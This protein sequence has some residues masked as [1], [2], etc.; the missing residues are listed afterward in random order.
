[1]DHENDP[2]GNEYPE[3]TCICFVCLEQFPPQAVT[4]LSCGTHIGCGPC[5][6][7]MFA[8]ALK[9]EIS[10]PPSCC[11]SQPSIPLSAVEHVLETSFI[12]EYKTKQIEYATDPKS[13]IYCANPRCSTFLLQEPGQEGPA[14]TNIDCVKCGAITCT[15]CKE[16]ITV[17]E[18]H[19]CKDKIQNLG[20]DKD[21]RSKPCP[22]CRTSVELTDAC[23]H[24]R[25]SVC[26]YEFCFV[27]LQWQYPP[28]GIVHDCPPYGDPDY[29]ENGYDERGFHRDTGLDREGY[30]LAG[31]NADHVSR[32]GERR[33]V[34]PVPGSLVELQD[35]GNDGWGPERNLDDE[36]N[37]DWN[38]GDGGQW[39]Q[40]VAQQWD[41][42][43]E[44]PAEDRDEE[45]ARA[46]GLDD[47]DF[48]EDRIVH[49]IR[50]L[51]LDVTAN[52]ADYERDWEIESDGHPADQAAEYQ[53]TEE[54]QAT[55]N[56]ATEQTD[57][58]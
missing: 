53:A 55:E 8:A 37:A 25:C 3:W 43:D 49:G 19:S 32:K 40:G 51:E 48:E 28:G 12:E 18:E 42:G 9:S 24:L 15:G 11:F 36:A 17:D 22:Y 4:T 10:Y 31:Y 38:Q 45:E 23:N 14:K 27:C 7:D 52:G 5:L 44:E 30:D 58:W 46:A 33:A 54:D 26:R 47:D 2:L 21:N 20:Y 29:D 35:A 39:D 50:A 34:I 6:K 1:M 57:R 16:V 13:R 41:H 56:Q